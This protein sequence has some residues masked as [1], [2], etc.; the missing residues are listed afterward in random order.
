[1]SKTPL[2]FTDLKTHDNKYCDYYDSNTKDNA[3]AR[4][5]SKT[6]V[7]TNDKIMQIINNGMNTDFFMS[8]NIN[9][10]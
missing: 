4:K 7:I 8:A 9:I 5:N 3:P 1:M 6:I 10:R 2:F